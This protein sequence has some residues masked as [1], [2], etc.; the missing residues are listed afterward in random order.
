MKFSKNL[1]DSDFFN[2]CEISVSNHAPFFPLIW[3]TCRGQ[4]FFFRVLT[5]HKFLHFY[6]KR[7][8]VYSNVIHQIKAFDEGKGILGVLTFDDLS[9]TQGQGRTYQIFT[10]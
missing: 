7:Q 3:I 4:Q 1:L 6:S 10:V 8:K 2:V 9:V 5:D